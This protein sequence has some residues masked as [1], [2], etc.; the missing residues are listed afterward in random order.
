MA[1]KT[2]TATKKETRGFDKAAKEIAFESEFLALAIEHPHAPNKLKGAVNFL[3]IAALDDLRD[4]LKKQNADGHMVRDILP[5]A[6]YVRP[7]FIDAFKHVLDGMEKDKGQWRVLESIQKHAD[8]GEVPPRYPHPAKE[9]LQRWRNAWPMAGSSVPELPPS[10]PEAETARRIAELIEADWT[11]PVIRDL[12]RHICV[13]VDCFAAERIDAD[14]MD[15]KLGSGDEVTPEL[16]RR[17]VPAMLRKVGDF[18]LSHWM[19][20]ELDEPKRKKRGGKS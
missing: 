19:P 20:H 5:H 4:Y 6:Y 3:L 17:E 13:T 15:F 7:K 8:R 1:R 2:L 10:D 12:L 9:Y 16:V 18:K 11:P 14:T